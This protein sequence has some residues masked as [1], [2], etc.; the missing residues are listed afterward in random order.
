MQ[1]C[2]L[3]SSTLPTSSCVQLLT[4]SHMTSVHFI[5]LKGFLSHGLFL[6]SAQ[7]PSIHD[8]LWQGI[9][10][11]NCSLYEEPF[12]LHPAPAGFPYYFYWKRQ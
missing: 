2:V 10:Q 8:I 4:L 7:T 12:A 11:F 9:P 1:L 5:L 3:S 6:E